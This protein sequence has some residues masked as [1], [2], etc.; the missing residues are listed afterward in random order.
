MMLNFLTFFYIYSVFY[1]KRI[2]LS[3][4]S[5]L[6]PPLAPV[7]RS[8]VSGILSQRIKSVRLFPVPYNPP[9]QRSLIRSVVLDIESVPKRNRSVF[10]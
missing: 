3:R 8:P 10:S 2:C 5:G 7:I 9:P 4:L 1:L 6:S